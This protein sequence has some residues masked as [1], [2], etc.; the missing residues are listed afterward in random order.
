MVKV[1]D[2]ETGPLDEA[3][4]VVGADP[5]LGWEESLKALPGPHLGKQEE[6]L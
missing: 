3:W 1:W 4:S 5:S 2:T 6:R